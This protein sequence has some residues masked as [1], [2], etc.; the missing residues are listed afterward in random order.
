VT[1]N[2]TMWQYVT[3]PAVAVD[4]ANHLLIETGL[5]DPLLRA[6]H[7]GAPG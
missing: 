2:R 4:W 6:A 5:K 7:L 3:T 1:S